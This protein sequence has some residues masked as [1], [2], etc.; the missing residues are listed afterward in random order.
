MLKLANDEPLA[1]QEVEAVSCI[2]LRQIWE[3]M[4]KFAN[5]EPLTA[6]GIGLVG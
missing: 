3:A 5:D 1:E 2:A 4:F 6:S